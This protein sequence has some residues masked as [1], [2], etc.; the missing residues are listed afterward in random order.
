M[1]VAFLAIADFAASVIVNFPN[2][3][4]SGF[5]GAYTA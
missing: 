5:S 3:N 4:W 2:W 1:R